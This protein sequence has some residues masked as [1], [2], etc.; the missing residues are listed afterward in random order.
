MSDARRYAVWPEPRSRSRSLKG[1]R[2]SVPHGTNFYV[3]LVF[4]GM[5]SVF[6]WFWLSCQYLPSDWLEWFLCGSLT[7][8]GDRVHKAQAKECLWFS[9]FILLFHCLIV[10]C[11]FYTPALCDIFL[12]PMARYSLFVLKVPLNTNKITLKISYHMAVY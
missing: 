8:A 9:W 11:V 7:M 5:C 10:W 12:T 3:L 1:S 6:W 2:P 4:V